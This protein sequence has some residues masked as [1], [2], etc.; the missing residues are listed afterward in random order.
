MSGNSMFAYTCQRSLSF[1]AFSIFSWAA[2]KLPAFWKCKI[3]SALISLRSEFKSHI[4]IVNF[5]SST[6]SASASSG[7][8]VSTAASFFLFPMLGSPAMTRFARSIMLRNSSSR[9]NFSTWLISKF[10][11]NVFS[12]N[13]K[14]IGASRRIVASV[15]ENSASSSPSSRSFKMRSVTPAAFTFSGFFLRTLYIFST[16]PNE[17]MRVVAVFSPMP[18]MPIILSDGSPRR[19]L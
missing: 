13:T 2:S 14:S 15:F 5:L 6:G 3:S 8:I 4:P 7:E 12:G 18:A 17:V 11:R 1:K 16:V 10:S 19:P 9:N